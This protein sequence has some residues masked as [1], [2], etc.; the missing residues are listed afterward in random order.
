VLLVVESLPQPLVPLLTGLDTRGDVVPL[1]HPLLPSALLARAPQ[2]LIPWLALLVWL[3]HASLLLP[4]PSLPPPCCWLAG[5]ALAGSLPQPSLLAHPSL[6]W[7]GPLSHAAAGLLKL[8]TRSSLARLL[9]KPPS[10]PA[11]AGLA[12]LHLRHS[13]RCPKFISLHCEQFQSSGRG[14]LPPPDDPMP[15]GRAAVHLRHSVRWP[16]FISLH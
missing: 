5:V 1:P 3:P 9:L 12:V 16:K 10:R 7:L 6:C 4:Q 11:P 2:A 13:V 14:C 15:G 8:P